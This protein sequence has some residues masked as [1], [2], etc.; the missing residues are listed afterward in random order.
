V[1]DLP[2]YETFLPSGS[3]QASVSVKIRLDGTH[4]PWEPTG[5]I[6]VLVWFSTPRRPEG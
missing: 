4:D 3:A 5:L 1:A 6:N 2:P